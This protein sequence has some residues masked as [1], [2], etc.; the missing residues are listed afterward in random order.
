MISDDNRKFVIVTMVGT[1]SELDNGYCTEVELLRELKENAE[2]HYRQSD[3]SFTVCVW[4]IRNNTST[5]YEYNC[6]KTVQ[7]TVTCY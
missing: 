6:E 4:D 1:D 2:D 3:E 7:V 5:I